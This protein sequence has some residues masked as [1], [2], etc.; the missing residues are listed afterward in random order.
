MEEAS[1]Y[2]GS[3]YLWR[4]WV[5]ME[6]V[7]IYGGLA[8]KTTIW[9]EG[10]LSKTEETD[11]TNY[12]Q[13]TTVEGKGWFRKY[14]STT[15]KD[16]VM[17]LHRKTNT[18]RA[19]PVSNP[20]YRKLQTAKLTHSSIKKITYVERTGN[21][22]RDSSNNIDSKSETKNTDYATLVTPSTWS[23]DGERVILKSNT[24][25]P[26]SQQISDEDG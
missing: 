24:K 6:E 10:N 19:G 21:P 3:E 15:E 8:F 22:I 20:I 5:S 25:G 12:R 14:A 7:S 16:S 2:G 26:L 11:L 9:E 23:K 13:R 18:I 4:K 1:I 17:F